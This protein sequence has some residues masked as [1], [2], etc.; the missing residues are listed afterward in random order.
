MLA[1]AAAAVAG[2]QRNFPVPAG[3]LRGSGA[4]FHS[5][6]LLRAPSSCLPPVGH[7]DVTLLLPS[8]CFSL[9]LPRL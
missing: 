9:P 2:V 8:S 3:V 5:G 4:C 6:E 1:A 7:N